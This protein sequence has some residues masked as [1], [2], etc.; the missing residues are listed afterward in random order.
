MCKTYHEANPEAS[1]CVFDPASTVGGVW[2]KEKIYPGLHTNNLIGSF[3]F[4]DFPMTPSRYGLQRGD[5]MPG[6]VVHR[7]MEDA[8]E[9][10]GIDRY[11]RLGT[12][13]E[14]AEMKDNGQWIIS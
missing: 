7:Y 2:S 3:E 12:K 4:S 1:I 11:L 6:E 8:V 10:F 14:S 5:H 13:V 9:Y